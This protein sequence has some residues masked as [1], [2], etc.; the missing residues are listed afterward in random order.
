[1]RR[2]YVVASV[3]WEDV[4]WHQVSKMLTTLPACQMAVGYH[5]K[6]LSPDRRKETL[7]YRL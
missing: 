5:G 6:R 4:Q 3:Q 2:R 7:I 1:M